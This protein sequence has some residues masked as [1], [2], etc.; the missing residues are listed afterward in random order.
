MVDKKIDKQVDKKRRALLLGA[1]GAAVAGGGGFTLWR[2]GYVSAPRREQTD[3]Y[4]PRL[5]GWF[6]PDAVVAR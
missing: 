5:G 6:L 4:K 3:T 1:A 2:A